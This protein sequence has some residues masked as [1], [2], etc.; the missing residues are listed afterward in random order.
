MQG[1]KQTIIAALSYLLIAF[2]LG[3]IWHLI[4]FKDAYEAFGVYTRPHPIIPL[5]ALCAIIQGLILAYLYPRW[6]GDG[7][8]L[9]SA[10]KF[11]LLMGLFYASGTVIAVA[12]KSQIA[13]LPLWFGLNFAFHFLQ[14]SLTALVFAAVFD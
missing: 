7:A 10:F 6:R 2:P 12:A 13:N 1:I 9:P 11:F 3:Y 4:L 14:F 5:G 8:R